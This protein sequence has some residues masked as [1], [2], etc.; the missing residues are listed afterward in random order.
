V[1]NAQIAD[2]FDELADLYELDG[3]VQY[4]VLAYRTAARTVRE[5]S[6]SVEQ[7]VRDGRVTELPGIGK[8]LETKLE[9]L[10]ETGD[11]TQAQKLRA[12]FPSGLIAMMRLPGFG[13]KRARRLYDELGIDSL[14]ALR[15]AAEQQQLRGL[16][17]FG[18][19]VEEKLLEQL[20]AGFDGRPAPRVL[21]SRALPIA[22]EVVAA[23]RAVPGAERVEVAGSL[24]RQADSVKDLDVIAT[25]A[26]PAALV[27]ALAGLPLVESVDSSGDAGGRVTTHTG[28]KV[29]L[30]VVEPD[31]FGNVLQHFTGSKEHNVALREAA[32][33]RGLHV[34]EYGILDDATGETLRCRTEEEVYAKLGLPWIPPELRQGRGELEAAAA[35]AL[36]ELVTLTDLRGDLHSHTTL[37][38][39]V[40]DIEAMVEGAR[41]RGYEYLAITDHSASH[42]FG[43]HVDADMLRAQIERVRALDEQLDGFE[44]LIGTETNVLTDGSLDYDDELLAELDWIVA[45]VH[46][47]FGMSERDMTARMVAA[48]E[49]PL[50]DVIGHPT[51]RKIEARAPYALDVERVIE[52]AA[53]THTMLEIN[54]A[55]DRRDLNELHAR[56]AAE[57]GVM[58][59]VDSD[60]HSVRNLGLIRYGIA[61]ARRAWLSRAQV[62]NTRPWAELAQL[63]KRSRAAA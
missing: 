47:S 6:V 52:A 62:A 45:S 28:L 48:I 10:I 27:R 16:R 61:T 34:S 63:R 5:A 43:N 38:D 42:G 26:D 3:A 41:S 2:A 1:T 32:V 7:L 11:T 58:I 53:R 22:E 46:T 25:A 8:T 29:D 31:Q 24:R 37:S 55:P 59:V 13:P 35:D 49:H 21:L 15:A 51:G 40:D 20:A 36:P 23:L 33:K 50:V 30:K 18:A 12:Q 17:G 44:L 56:A 19:K 4:R 14:E 57:A 60:A 9:T 39:G 54:A